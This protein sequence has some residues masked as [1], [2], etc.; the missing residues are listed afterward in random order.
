LLHRLGGAPH[1]TRQCIL[2]AGSKGK[3]STVAMLSSILAA[4]GYTVGAFT[5]PHLHTPLERFALSSG[6]DK[7]TFAL[8]SPAQF[9]AYAGHIK[10]I[11]ETWDKPELGEPTR[12]EA[13]VAMAYRWYEE[14]T[15]DFAVMEIGIGGQLDAVNLAEPLLSIITNISLE[16]TQMLGNTLAHI[17][18]AKAGVLRPNTIGVIARQLPEARAAIAAAAHHIGARLIFAEDTPNL[19]RKRAN[20]HGQWFQVADQNQTFFLPLLGRH[21]LENAAAVLLAVQALQS[22]G[23]KVDEAAV[24]AGLARTRWPG[25]FEIFSRTG[26]AV[27]VVDGAH[28]P[29]SMQQLCQALRDHFPGRR[30]HFVMSILRDKDARQMLQAAATLATRLTFTQTHAVRSLSAAQLMALAQELGLSDQS[31]V[32]VD[33]ARA[34]EQ[35]HTHATSADVIC[36]TGSLHLV[37]EARAW[38]QR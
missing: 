23:F 22:L 18:H 1:A 11:I 31:T 8:M 37:A 17:A 13:F 7:A 9:I 3:G 19:V 27:C 16:H 28:T 21:Q 6:V 15:V 35:A 4:A 2:V 36:V 34:F 25:R 14:H 30:V 5:G 20:T 12:F 26:Q 38:L 29:Y 10:K 33:I 32:A 24:R